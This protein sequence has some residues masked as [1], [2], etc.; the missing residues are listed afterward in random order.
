M[1]EANVSET[2]PTQNE[3]KGV[4]RKRSEKDPETTAKAS[5]VSNDQR[6]LLK[7]LDD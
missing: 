5:E 2:A 7:G 6:N 3:G 1:K 4:E